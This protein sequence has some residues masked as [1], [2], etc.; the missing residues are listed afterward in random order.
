MRRQTSPASASRDGSLVSSLFPSGLGAFLR[1]R[2]I[3]AIGLGC[4]LAGGAIVLALMTY[5]PADPSFNRAADAPATNLLGRTGAFASDLL[6]QSLGIAAVALG[7]GL[8]AWGWRMMS[9]GRLSSWSLR[10]AAFLAAVLLSSAMLAP[11]GA[12]PSWPLQSGLGGAVGLLMVG[13]FSGLTSALFGPFGPPATGAIAGIGA[14][15][16]ALYTLEVSRAEVAAA[17]RAVARALGWA[18]AGAKVAG[19]RGLG[20][21]SSAARIAAASAMDG[22]SRLASDLGWA[23][24]R[25]A[26]PV[27]AGEQQPLDIRDLGP[28]LAEP[29]RPAVDWATFDRSLPLQPFDPAPAARAAAEPRAEP[30]AAP[31]ASGV[32]GPSGSPRIVAR[33][34]AWLGTEPQPFDSGADLA[35]PVDRQEPI[36]RG[37]AERDVRDTAPA[38][39]PARSGDAI[40]PARPHDP[41]EFDLDG[42]IPHR[43]ATAARDTSE[44]LY[45]AADAD[46]S[47][48]DITI[49]SPG[50]HLVAARERASER[51]PEKVETPLPVSASPDHSALDAMIAGTL[52]MAA[53]PL[54]ATERPSK[55]AEPV[56]PGPGSAPA[57]TRAG[58]TTLTET[59]YSDA[60]SAAR[61]ANRGRFVLPPL[62]MLSEPTVNAQVPQQS[63]ESLAERS[64]ALVAVLQDFGVRG[65]IVKVR[66][67]PVVTLYELEPAPGTKSSRVISLADDIARSMSAVSVRIAVVPGRNVIGIELPNPKRETVSLRALLS[68]RDYADPGIRLPLALGKD[69]GGAPVF[70]DLARMPHLL[71]AGTTGSGKSVAVNAM[72]LS[73]LQRLPPERCRFI[74]IDP[75]ML[76]LSVYNDIPHLLSP[77]VTEPGKAIVALKWAVREMEDRYRLMSVL[78]VR[79][80]DSY[81]A[82]IAEARAAGELLTRRVQTGFDPETGRPVMEEQPLPLDPLP[83]IVIVVD[84]MADLM[85]VAGKDIEAAIQR[86]AQMARAAGIH[87]IMATQR[88]SVD[89]ITGTI[90]ANFPTRISFQV[91]SKIDSRTILGEQGAEQ[92]LG[93]GD[94][95]YMVGGGRITRVHGPFVSDQEVDRVVAHLKAQA[96]PDYIEG[97]TDEP[98]SAMPADEPGGGGE[99]E[100]YNQAVALVMRERKAS[101]SF[102]QRHLQIGYNRAARMIELMEQHGIVSKANHAGKREVLGASMGG[103]GDTYAAD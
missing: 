101:T 13:H 83:F 16:L 30:A 32:D 90:K 7:L 41:A 37:S 100:L 26:A 4:A 98:E 33:L 46:P 91:T 17:A 73:L 95:L 92:L 97:L 38:D 86:L 77:V 61:P 58:G 52:A 14:A 40:G 71:V 11:L 25:P 103:P 54:P 51:V 75:K 27:E 9:R 59:R 45:D 34:S 96:T 24:E 63:V 48:D 78:G 21:G 28:G 89:V 66:P 19:A 39:S 74:M 2:V 64:R 47:S 84:E 57:P 23:R 18:A 22:A 31:D 80:I 65:E 85:L 42:G 50:A 12:P 93:Q 53:A 88:P 62:S 29:E 3:E 68:H 60:M 69:I 94:M 99:D 20:V 81:N 76:E 43:H 10:L 36:F 6:L 49:P 56:K 44:P 79:N 15:A 35:D 82:R 8:V 72:I 67:G 87:L 5:N 1:R 70:A 55:A 102:I